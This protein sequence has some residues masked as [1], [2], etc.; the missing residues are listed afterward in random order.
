ME[1]FVVRY[2]NLLVL[3]VLLVAQILGL[4]MQVR[5]A[6]TGQAGDGRSVRLIR[7]WA[8]S[9]VT[10]PERLLHNTGSGIS[11]IW[12]NYFDL[13]H[14]RQQNADLQKTV[15]RLRLEQAALLE[16]AKQGQ[17]LQALLNFQQKYVYKTLPAQVIGSSGSDQ[18]RVFYIDKGKDE[19]I[20]RDMAVITPDGI[21]GKIRDVFPHSA[22]VLAI[23][24][25][26]SGAGVIM[27]STRIRGILR[28]NASG[29]PQ[30]EDVI[31]DQRIKPGDPVL[32]AGGDEIFPRGLPVG[33]VDK[34][35]NDPER[36]GFVQVVLKPAA[37]LDQLDEVLVITSTQPRFPPDQQQDMATSEAL[38]GAEAEQQKTSEG[39][40]EK[41]PGLI[42]PNVPPDQQPLNDT[43]N[44]GYPSKPAMAIHPDRFTPGN[45]PTPV[46]EAG[47]A[48]DTPATNPAAS[49]PAAAG[50]AKKKPD[51]PKKPASQPQSNP[52]TPP[53]APQGEN[54]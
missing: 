49:S 24:D 43:S 8:D 4:A 52:A 45:A 31:R 13:R 9:I 53:A 48:A 32:T 25:Q 26:S 7:Y 2:R 46:P 15:D 36:D 39:M 42:V 29:R 16:D 33:V 47:G 34:V 3:L 21:V 54:R 1:S 51:S 19:G 6:G 12:N 14:V 40:A 27:E 5:R 23:N 18:S 10:P 28:G 35:V 44:P 22:Q 17:R 38:K 30:I 50:T 41:L 37:H 11:W 20:D